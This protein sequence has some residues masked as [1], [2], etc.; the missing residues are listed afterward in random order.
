MNP[1]THIYV[2]YTY[3]TWNIESLRNHLRISEHRSERTWRLTQPDE[4]GPGQRFIK[5]VCVHFYITYVCT[6]YTSKQQIHFKTC[7]MELHT[8]NIYNV[9]IYNICT[10][11]HAMIKWKDRIVSDQ[12]HIQF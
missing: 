8:Y 7:G 10:V 9:Y 3:Q 11:K 5:I 6:L 4:Y 12:E 2:R 1:Y